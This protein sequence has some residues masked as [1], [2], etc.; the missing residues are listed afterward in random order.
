MMNLAIN[1]NALMPEIIIATSAM[2]VLLLG[3][4]VKDKNNNLIYGISQITLLLAAMLVAHSGFG[5]T[6]RVFNDM[7]IIDPAGNF[8]KLLSFIATS[9]VFL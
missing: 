9:F 7:H 2:L 6:Y 8:L 5:P 3:L 1:I 4:F